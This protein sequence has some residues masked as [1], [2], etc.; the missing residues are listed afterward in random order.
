MMHDYLVERGLRD[1][2]EISLVMPLGRPIPP[3][4][5]ASELLLEAFAERGINW[6]PEQVVR[7]LDPGTKV[8]EFADG[9]EMPFDLFLGVPKHQVPV[10]VEESGMCVD[11]WIP[12]DRLTLATAF[13]GVYAVGDVTSVGTPKAGVFAEG[14]AA[15]VAEAIIAE[16]R[17]H[18]ASDEY[19]GRGMCYLE[20]GDG[21]VARVDITFLAGQ[22]P[23]GTLEAP[24]LALAREKSDF[25]TSRVR[26]WLGR[27]WSP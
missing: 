7:N 14:Q 13:P 1:R 24:S 5:D 27:E 22:P 15:V 20:F 10:A 17:G 21:Q 8:A 2:S 12:V 23:F 4:P 18:P 26:R 3:S 9:S 25:G 11:G 6:Y 19:D 16:V